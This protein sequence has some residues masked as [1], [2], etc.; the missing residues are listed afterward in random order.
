[1]DIFERIKKIIDLKCKGN[2][3]IEIGKDLG[4]KRRTVDEN[5][6]IGVYMN[7]LRQNGI[8]P[9]Q[10]SYTKLRKMK[11][12]SAPVQRQNANSSKKK[13][14]DKDILATI[15]LGDLQTEHKIL[16]QFKDLAE[17]VMRLMRLDDLDDYTPNTQNY[18][19]EIMHRLNKYLSD[20][21]DP[22][23]VIIADIEN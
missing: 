23:R 21:I 1:M 3:S 2:S 12:R 6:E 4:I 22:R 5:Y 13:L 10:Y 20:Q 17:K 15:T 9:L 14:S 7:T 19:L 8:D 11:R 16:T 18:C